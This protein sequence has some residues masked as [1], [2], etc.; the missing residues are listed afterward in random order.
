MKNC[1]G[2][3][4][5]LCLIT[6]IFVFQNASA[7]ELPTYPKRINYDGGHVVIHAPQVTAWY[8]FETIELLSAVEAHPTG[9]YTEIYAT[10]S[11]RANAK[12]DVRRRLVTISDVELVKLTFA[13]GRPTK[14]EHIT[15]LE[16]A[17]PEAT[18]EVSLDLVLA[19][20]ADDFEVK[21]DEGIRAE[22]PVIHYSDTP[23]LLVLTQG[24]PV[25]TAV[26]D[27]GMF[28]VANTN[29]PLFTNEKQNKW[30]LLNDN[31]WLYSKSLDGPWKFAGRLPKELRDLPDD[32][33][34]K[35][36]RSAAAS[37]KKPKYDP[38]RVIASDQPAE[39]IVTTGEPKLLDVAGD[40]KAVGNTV[41]KLFRHQQHWY[42]LVS[43]RWFRTEDLANGSWTHAETLP[44]D[45]LD[46]PP[47]GPYGEVVASV[48]GTAEA[49]AAVIEAQLPRYATI[50]ANATPGG[51]VSYSGEPQFEAIGDTAVT[52]AVNTASDV[53]SSS[54][55]YYW[56]SDGMWFVSDDPN[57]PWVPARN[58]PDEIYTIP[59]SSPSHHVTY[60]HVHDWEDDHITYG[61]SS[62]YF[63]TYVAYGM[64]VWGT[65]YYYNP[66]I[67][68][69]PFNPWYPVYYPYAYTYGGSA[70][71]NPRTGAYGSVSRA[72]GPYGGWGYASAYNPRTGRYASAEAIWDNNEWAMVGEA[73]NPRTGRSFETS[74]YYDAD[75]NRWEID[76]TLA[77][78]RGEI[79]IERTI[80]DGRA[81]TQYETSRG[82]QGDFTRQRNSDGSIRSSG[83]FRTAD[84]RTI[85]TEGSRSNGNSSRSISGSD[86]G[87]GTITRERDRDSV[88]RTGEFSRSGETLSTSTDR[89]AD[90]TR[91]TAESSSG[92]Q[93]GSVTRKGNT[94]T[95]GRNA[96][97]DLYAG[98]NGEVYRRTDNGWSQRQ[99]GS[100]NNV[101]R[102]RSS[103]NNRNL[104]RSFNARQR[105]MTAS[106]NRGGFS[107][108]GGMRR[109]RR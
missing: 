48:P 97:G 101:N 17:I 59:P 13:D 11:L 24:E 42:Y 67:W 16:T 99:N 19:H 66:Y 14:P 29:W 82:G 56:C 70:F 53:L 73:Y 68:Y 102:N 55:Q 30:Y 6:F 18:R 31:E 9:V 91:R 94:T 25:V 69:D 8:N 104:N 60:V 44:E 28:F 77:G 23:A 54:D 36:A 64:V 78:R 38:P 105:G 62:G 107:R 1:L 2:A 3:L 93:L 92:A 81:R 7:Q 22:P 32:A 26:E 43:G 46:I 5:A 37:W 87:S 71:Y 103:G 100:W 10:A 47:D 4:C 49:K 63:G 95:V 98:R 96:A 33:N 76:S 108:G 89:T 35:Q 61:H 34:W 86:G 40:L 75:D 12:P 72:Y 57:G 90:R 106:R 21:T 109:G 52:R 58:I 84:G 51:Q 88:S 83:E 65:G 15:L 85:T 74:R 27:D 20:L 45:F 80:D 79:D 50:E 39:L 41:S